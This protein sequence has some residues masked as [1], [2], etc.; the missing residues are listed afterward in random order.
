MDSSTVAQLADNTDISARAASVI[1]AVKYRADKAQELCGVLCE[2]TSSYDMRG[3]AVELSTRLDRLRVT[4]D[5]LA[6]Y[7]E[8]VYSCGRKVLFDAGRLCE[9]LCR[10]FNTALADMG[11]AVAMPLY[12]ESLYIFADGR[13]TFIAFLNMLHDSLLFSDGEAMPQPVLHC[14]DRTGCVVIRILNIP[15]DCAMSDESMIRLAVVKRY[16]EI[17]GGSM[18]ISAENRTLMLSLPAASA[19][20]IATSRLE[21]DIHGLF[22]TEVERYIALLRTEREKIANVQ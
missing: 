4:V 19:A 9:R 14:D 15:P 22:E 1:S 3:V 12:D 21:E 20:D 18:E 7:G 11:M 2:N 16:A 17:S 5:C 8:V 6:A 13:H 10:R